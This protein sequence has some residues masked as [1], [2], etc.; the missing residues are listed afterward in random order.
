MPIYFLDELD[1]TLAEYDTNANELCSPRSTNT[2]NESDSILLSSKTKLLA[3]DA[4][5]ASIRTRLDFINL[6]S[7]FSDCLTH[8]LAKLYV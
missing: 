2:S 6:S 8:E 1:K 3:N 5:A 4:N 7:A